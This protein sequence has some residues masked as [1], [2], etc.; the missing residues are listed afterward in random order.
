MRRNI[1]ELDGVRAVAILA[2]IAFHA[3]DGATSSVLPGVAQWIGFGW[4]GVDLFFVLSG[5]LITGI[6]L[7]TKGTPHAWRNFYA[8]RILRIFP[9]YYL[10]LITYFHLLPAVAQHLSRFQHFQRTEEAWYWLYVCNWSPSL[11]MAHAQLTHLWSLSIVEQFYVFWPLLVFSLSRR[12]VWLL[13]AAV[14]VIAP[15]IRTANLLTLAE[16]GP[17]LYRNTLCR[18]DTLAFG[19]LGALLVRDPRGLGLAMRARPILLTAA[20]IGVAVSIAIGGTSSYHPA[21]NTIGFTS[22]AI[23]FAYLILWASAGGAGLHAAL[24]FGPL[25]SIGKYSYAMYIFHVPVVALLRRVFH[26]AGTHNRL[27]F[28]MLLA[29]EIAAAAALSYAGGWVSW[30]LFENPFLQLKSHF[31]Y[32]EKPS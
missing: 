9:L 6:L 23:L 16:S 29:G 12:A 13:C 15:C 32:R 22:L 7:D 31:E 26:L 25:R 11:G 19:A 5:F 10:A 28:G 24:R 17:L 20:G 14:L 21:M 3:G 4:F 27:A 18:F 30:R 2:V 1:P 8:R